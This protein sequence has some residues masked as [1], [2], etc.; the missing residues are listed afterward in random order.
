MLERD[1]GYAEFDVT[2]FVIPLKTC[3]WN[4]ELLSPPL[5]GSVFPHGSRLLSIVSLPLLSQCPPVIVFFCSRISSTSEDEM[6]GCVQFMT[7]GVSAVKCL[8]RKL[9]PPLLFF[10][11]D[12]SWN[13]D[14][15][16]IRCCATDYDT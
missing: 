3:E 12:C 1:G 6:V 15:C 5:L 4:V 11:C 13:V 9:C 16:G 7:N 14:V 2:C 10:L 8:Q